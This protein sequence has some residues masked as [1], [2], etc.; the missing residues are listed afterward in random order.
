MT[1]IE[2]LRASRE[3]GEAYAR[4][5]GVSAGW[6]GWIKWDDKHRYHGLSAHDLV[7]DD[8]IPDSEYIP[9]LTKGR[10]KAATGDRNE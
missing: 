10:W 1:I 7:A 6:I 5:P 4:P 3:T 9:L 2:A 8:W